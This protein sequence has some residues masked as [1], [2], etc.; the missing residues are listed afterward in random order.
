MSSA[1]RDLTSRSVYRNMAK[2]LGSL[3]HFLQATDELMKF[4]DV[5]ECELMRYGPKLISLMGIACNTL[6][7]DVG[8]CLL[9]LCSEEH[10]PYKAAYFKLLVWIRAH[11][12]AFPVYMEGSSDDPLLP[13]PPR[14]CSRALDERPTL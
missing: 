2:C 13:F 11:R 8:V 4:A 3:E 14:D 12:T 1:V 6:R 9:V 5:D 7:R 10:V